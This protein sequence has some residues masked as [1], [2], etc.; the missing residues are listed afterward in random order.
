MKHDEVGGSKVQQHVGD[1]LAGNAG[2]HCD[3]V[4]YHDCLAGCTSDEGDCT[5]DC[6]SD[7]SVSC[8]LEAQQ[9]FN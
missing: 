1:D 4:G 7:H 3:V 5:S 9:H 2:Q 8:D 6:N